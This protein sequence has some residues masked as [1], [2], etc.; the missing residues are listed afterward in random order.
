LFNPVL[1]KS[2]QWRTKPV[3]DDMALHFAIGY[4]F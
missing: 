2:D 4:P 1:S 3:W